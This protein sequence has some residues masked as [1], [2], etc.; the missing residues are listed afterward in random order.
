MNKIQ[1]LFSSLF[2]YNLTLLN[3]IPANAQI[4]PDNTL[5][6]ESSQINSNVLIK[7]FNADQINGGATRG[8]NLFHSFSE[9]NIKDGQ[10]VYFAN[11]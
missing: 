5:E 4:T 1:F 10:K 8:S 11:K 9:F 7:G 6:N 2:L 3:S